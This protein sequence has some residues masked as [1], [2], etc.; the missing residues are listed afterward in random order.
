MKSRFTFARALICLSIAS[1]AVWTTA[2]AEEFLSGIPW[3][4]PKVI[5]PPA[6]GEPPSD[7]IVL[8]NGK[9][10]SQW[11]G[12]DQWI[13]K[14]G[15]AISRGGGISTKQ[16]F[17]D[18]QVHVEWAAP[19]KV[20]GSGQGRGNSGV[21][22]MGSYEVQILDS[23]QNKTY[24]DG[25]AG[26]VYK[27]SPPLVNASKKPG[28]WQ[29]YDI[30]FKAPVFDD[31]GKLTRPAYISVLHN[32]IAVQNNFEIQ[33]TTA[34]DAA[35]KYNVHPKKLPIQLQFHGNPVRFRNIW[36]RD[37]TRVTPEKVR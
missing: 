36:V 15:Y 33:G 32:G 23:H 37:L 1:A 4:E 11:E 6:P 3:L 21:Y 34:W 28:E 18:C 2:W 31:V 12:G 20:E 26:S 19:E 25:Q 17:G 7:A 27:Q 13:V 29:T 24:Y 30:V 14:E 8:F 5:T 16:T 35:P 9:D 22:L 10:L